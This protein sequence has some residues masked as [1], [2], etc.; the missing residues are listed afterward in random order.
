MRSLG[1]GVISATTQVKVLS[2]ETIPVALGQ[3]YRCLEADISMHDNGECMSDVPG[4]ESVAG[5]RT[6]GCP[7]KKKMS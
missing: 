1:K 3:G 5:E 2:R 6:M 4:F 7:S